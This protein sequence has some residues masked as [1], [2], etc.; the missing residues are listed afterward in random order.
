MRVKAAEAVASALSNSVWDALASQART[1]ISPSESRVVARLNLGIVISIN[2]E[3]VRISGRR[4]SKGG[5]YR[6]AEY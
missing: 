3:E 5:S 4:R 2:A 6:R 1:M